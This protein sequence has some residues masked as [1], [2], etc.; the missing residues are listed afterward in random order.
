[1]TKDLVTERLKLKDLYPEKADSL[2]KE[3]NLEADEIELIRKGVIT[4]KSEIDKDERAIINYISTD[5]KDRDNEILEHDGVI[6]SDYRKNPIVPWAHDYRSLPIGKNIWIKKDKKG[7]VAK[8]VFLK[9]QFAEEVYRLYTE[10]IAGTGPAMKAWSVGFIPLKWEK[11]EGKDDNRPSNIDN[12]TGALDTS[13]RRIYKKWLLLEYSAVPVPSN[14][15][16]LTLM[17][18]KGLIKSEELKKDIEKFIE[19][20]DNLI[21]EI[22]L[23]PEVTENYIRIPVRKCV[24]TATI[25]ISKKEGIKAL[26]CGKEKKVHTYLFLKA[27]G[28]TLEKAKKWVAEHDSGK[29]ED[30]KA[31]Y[32]CEC[33]KCGYKMSSDKHCNTLKCPKCGGQM[34][35]TERPGPGQ[36]SVDEEV[37]ELVENDIQKGVIPFRETPKAPEDEKWDGPREV[38]EAEVSDLK[39]MCA[40]YDSENPDI[41][42]SYK[43]PHHK[44]KGHAVVWRAVA[45]AMASLLGAR[46]GVQIPDKDKK[47]V[48]N[49]LVKEYKRFDKTPPEF[50]EYTEEELKE[51]FRDVYLEESKRLVDEYLSDKGTLKIT[52]ELWDNLLEQIEDLRTEIKTLKEGRVLSAKNRKLIENCI[53]K[54]NEAITALNEILRAT[55]PPKE[56]GIELEIEENKEKTEKKKDN[57]LEVDSEVLVKKVESVLKDKIGRLIEDK[58]NKLRGKV[59]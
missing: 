32:N 1:M 9:H 34:R 24:I 26:Y 4:E 14:P 39:I 12:D 40:W 37:I 33:I 45:A 42:S 5:V 17:V 2:A 7:L 53:S 8:T 35:R 6:L 54:M 47:G 55:E 29:S 43:L 27:K 57:K 18:K 38:R 58:I 46:G 19:I 59:E 25:D 48:Y 41:K 20:E 30:E 56:E 13:V 3:Y 16:A 51:I 44:A 22:V 10:D 49:H 23:K 21:K 36:E 15:E 11:P 28:W 31:K 50:R 52:K